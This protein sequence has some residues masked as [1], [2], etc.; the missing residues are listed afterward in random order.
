MNAV[1][2]IIPAAPYGLQGLLF[3]AIAAPAAATGEDGAAALSI[4][5]TQAVLVIA[6]LSACIGCIYMVFFFG[7]RLQ[8][9]AYLRDSL[10]SA[11]KHEDL[12]NR[13][14]ELDERRQTGWL[15]PA[16]PPPPGF[17]FMA[18]SIWADLAGS[19][20]VAQAATPAAEEYGLP[21]ETEEQR[22]QRED[23]I[24]RR[25]E[26]EERRVAPFQKWAEE[27]RARYLAAREAAEK[28]AQ[29][30]ANKMVPESIDISLLGGGWSFLLE[31]STVIVIIFV[32]LCLGLMGAIASKDTTTILASI[33]GYVLGRAS[34]AAAQR[35]SDKEPTGARLG[36]AGRDQGH[37]RR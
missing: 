35:G 19:G 16:K 33:A 21:N 27:E 6:A 32:L 8:T 12:R 15:D 20:R 2:M 1:R 36:G 5:F 30:R 7:R 26:E 31:F 14:R 23:R 25:K 4:S 18:P 17:E 9:S 34:S 24:R 13:L 29:E 3:S 10:V 37:A 11:M 28:E 22:K